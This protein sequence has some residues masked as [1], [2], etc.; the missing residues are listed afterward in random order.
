MPHAALE[1]ALGRAPE[2][3]ASMRSLPYPRPPPLQ[4]PLFLARKTRVSIN[5]GARI[6]EGGGGPRG[7]P[8][9]QQCRRPGGSPSWHDGPRA[10]EVLGFPPV[11]PRRR[12]RNSVH[13]V[14]V[15]MGRR[16]RHRRRGGGVRPCQLR[17]GLAV[18]SNR[19]SFLVFVVKAAWGCVGTWNHVPLHGRLAAGCLGTGG[20]P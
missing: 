17:S 1:S 3:R 20:S 14:S 9:L 16:S 11:E 15:L 5:A 4:I 7:L 2:S 10:G 6:R 12:L 8:S 19:S 13:P 18:E